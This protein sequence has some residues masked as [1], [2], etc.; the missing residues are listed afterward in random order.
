VIGGSLML[1]KIRSFA[2]AASMRRPSLSSE[3]L[4][5]S[6]GG[7][8]KG[9]LPLLWGEAQAAARARVLCWPRD[10]LAAWGEPTRPGFPLGETGK[11]DVYF[12]PRCRRR[13]CPALPRSF[14]SVRNRR[15][16]LLPFALLCGELC[17]GAGWDPQFQNGC[18]HLG[19][20]LR[21][22]R[23][24]LVPPRLRSHPNSAILRFTPSLV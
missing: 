4:R 2:V 13:F 24:E 9:G 19:I 11:G 23:E 5:S 7:M 6:L 15:F 16:A 18:C 8:H 22:L 17:S 14:L 12:L 21:L 3:N 20:E 1:V 10:V